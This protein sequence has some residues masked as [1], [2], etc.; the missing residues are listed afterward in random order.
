MIGVTRE[1]LEALPN[2]IRHEAIHGLLARV[3]LAELQP[4]SYLS[5]DVDEMS[6]KELRGVIEHSG[7]SHAG[8][9]EKAELVERAREALATLESESAPASEAA[10]PS[11]SAGEARERSE[12]T[13]MSGFAAMGAKPAELVAGSKQAKQRL[14][15]TMVEKFDFSRAASFVQ[16][17]LGVQDQVLVRSEAAEESNGEAAV[18]A[19][20]E[21]AALIAKM[22][23]LASGRIKVLL[24]EVPQVYEA[25]EEC[26]VCLNAESESPPDA[27]LYQ[28][29]H[30]CV[31][32]Q[33][34]SK[35]RKCPLCRAA[36]AAVLPIPTSSSS[37][38]S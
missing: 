35:L 20:E 25:T 13:E 12:P 37:P 21:R 36:I 17:A 28:C 18:E 31:H 24:A 19:E 8:L 11:H 1:N 6:I 22:E 38:K 5:K 14:G 15:G 34:A 9:L 30:Q 32:F 4:P 7:M 16:L 27:I 33:C 10:S 2:D 23:E 29:G 26:V 3:D